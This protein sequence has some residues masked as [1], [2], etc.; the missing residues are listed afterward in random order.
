MLC[1]RLARIR[2]ISRT[3]RRVAKNYVSYPTTSNRAPQNENGTGLLASGIVATL[4]L[5]LLLLASQTLLLLQ[6]SSIAE[7]VAFD[8]ASE[9]ATGNPN[10]SVDTIKQQQE[11]LLGPGNHEYIK[12]VSIDD[13]VIVTVVVPT[14]GLLSFGPASSKFIVRTARIRREVLRG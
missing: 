3:R 7:A 11:K 2:P 8:T 12:V 10:I 14:P 4:I 9:L 6:R 5:L 1:S 13:P